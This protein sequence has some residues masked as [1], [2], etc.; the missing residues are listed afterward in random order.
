MHK[1]IGA[2]G[3]KEESRGSSNVAFIHSAH[4]TGLNYLGPIWGNAA[5]ARDQDGR[6][7]MNS[8]LPPGHTNHKA[9]TH[10]GLWRIR[11]AAQSTVFEKQR[12]FARVIHATY[13]ILDRFARF[14]YS[15]ESTFIIQELATNIYHKLNDNTPTAVIRVSVGHEIG[16]PSVVQVD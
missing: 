5:R 11:H 3:Q 13:S 4:A 16:L 1:K 15:K 7:Q 14:A 2:L 10:A 9:V 8:V 6:K 12:E